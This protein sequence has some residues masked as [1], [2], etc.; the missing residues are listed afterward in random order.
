[1]ANPEI[2]M[3]TTLESKY[4]NGPNISPIKNIS[5]VYWANR[6]LI[7]STILPKRKNSKG[8]CFSKLNNFFSF[9]LSYLQ[10]KESENSVFFYY[11]P[12]KFRNRN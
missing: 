10:L 3:L 7:Q 12:K 5:K 4:I 9:P 2:R 11:F 8:F 1:M 6:L